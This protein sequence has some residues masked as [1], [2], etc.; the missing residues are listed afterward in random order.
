VLAVYRLPARATGCGH[1]F[2][3]TVELGQKN[4]FVISEGGVAPVGRASTAHRLSVGRA[5]CGRTIVR[6]SRVQSGDASGSGHVV[7][8]FTL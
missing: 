4:E 1:A 8:R 3:T 5:L 2:P 6:I 7:T